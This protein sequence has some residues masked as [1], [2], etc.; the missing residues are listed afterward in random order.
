VATSSEATVGHAKSTQQAMV[1][2]TV[3]V[4]H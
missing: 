4:S 1:A 3:A 2:P